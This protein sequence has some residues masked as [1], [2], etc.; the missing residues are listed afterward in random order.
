MSIISSQS[1]ERKSIKD[2]W[3]P[4]KFEISVRKLIGKIGRLEDSPHPNTS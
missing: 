1:G 2:L 4:I 3:D